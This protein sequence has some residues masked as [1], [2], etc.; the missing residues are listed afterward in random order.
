MPVQTRRWRWRSPPMASSTLMALLCIFW[1]T[2]V[3]ES[4]GLA[5]SLLSS[6]WQCFR[7]VTYCFCHTDA[8]LLCT[9]LLFFL[10][11]G[12]HQELRLGTLR[13][14]HVSVLGAAASAVL[15]LLLSAL[16]DRR[17]ALPVGSYAPVHLV[18]LGCHQRHQK[19]RGLSGWIS[20]ALWAGM[21]LGLTQVLSP[22]SPFFLHM[23]GLLAGLAYWAGV[24]SPL[25]L[26]EACLEGVH[27]W[28]VRRM[29][30]GG[31]AFGF[32]LPPAAAILPLTDPAATAARV[33]PVSSS[34][35]YW[36]GER[37]EQEREPGALLASRSLPPFSAPL[38]ASGV[39]FSALTD[40][41][42]LQAGIQ[43]SLQDMAKE[44]MK[45]SKSSVSSLRLQQLQRMGFPT[46]QAV[47]ALAATGH[48]EG[49]VSLLIGGHVGDETV[50]M[51]ESCRQP[52]PDHCP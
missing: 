34:T 7:L 41:E 42:Q 29:Q 48:V 18:L 24:F 27:N 19:Q 22:H 43:A 9:N 35:S 1:L 16:W 8:S 4:L 32:V 40:D 39:P 15:Y 28:M 5:P 36:S 52:L 45:L 26:P 3:G 6:P 14:L 12:W 17:P 50:V 11:L 2:G 20:V 38:E 44:E 49:A 13:Y 47:V 25:E 30:A 46:N 31:S 21:L 51:T 33:S 37:T 23:C 10:P